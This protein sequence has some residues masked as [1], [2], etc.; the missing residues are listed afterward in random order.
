[1]HTDYV[2]IVADNVPHS[3]YKEEEDPHIYK[4]KKSGRGPLGENWQCQHAVLCIYILCKVS[5]IVYLMYI[6]INVCNMACKSVCTLLHIDNLTCKNLKK[7][8]ILEK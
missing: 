6:C 1:M 7:S 3:E 4:S 5:D 8:C 2:D